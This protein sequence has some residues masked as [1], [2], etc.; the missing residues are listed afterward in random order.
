[1]SKMHENRRFM[2]CPTFKEGMKL[3]DQAKGVAPPPFGKDACAQRNGDSSTS[4][5]TGKVGEV[6]ELPAFENVSAAKYVDLLD[7]RRSVRKYADT[8]MSGA[9]LAFM[10]WSVHGIQTTRENVASFRPV[11]SGGAR[12]PFE[13][14][15]AVKNV[16]G[17]ASGLYLYLPTENIGEKRVTIMRCGEISDYD[18]TITEALAGQAWAAGAP[19]VLF[20]TCVPYKAEWRYHEMSHRVMLIDLGHV[21]QNAMLS[22]AAIGMGS[23]CMAAYDQAA[24]DRLLNVDGLEEYCVYAVSVGSSL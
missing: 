19:V 6:I 22:A 20:Y 7:T 14:Y 18:A 8:P 24:C 17:L 5:P 21:G 4:E 1:M 12:H 16:D 3:S 13:T 11:P 2:Q 15:V 23:C 10:L 9:Q